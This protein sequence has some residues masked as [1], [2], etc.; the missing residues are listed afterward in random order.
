[1]YCGDRNSKFTHKTAQ[2][3]ED[4]KADYVFLFAAA[5]GHMLGLMGELS[6]C[7]FVNG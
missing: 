5:R 4:V 2:L 1:M 6:V 7:C 3:V